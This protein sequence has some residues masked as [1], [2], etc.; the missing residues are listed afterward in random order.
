MLSIAMCGKGTF[1]VVSFRF[2][3]A[4]FRICKT[5]IHARALLVFPGRTNGLPK[6]TQKCF[7]G[8]PYESYEMHPKSNPG[9]RTTGAAGEQ[10]PQWEQVHVRKQVT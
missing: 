5:P 10:V 1:V 9:T 3:P 2:F 8:V 6:P 7:W 4:N